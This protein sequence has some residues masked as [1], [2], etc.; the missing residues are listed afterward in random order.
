M[1]HSLALVLA[2]AL[3]WSGAP[4]SPVF[5]ASVSGIPGFTPDTQLALFTR[6]DADNVERKTGGRN[7]RYRNRLEE[8]LESLPPEQ[9]AEARQHYEEIEEKRRLLRAELESLPPEERAARMEELR[10]QFSAM[11]EE[12]HAD[13]QERFRARW[14]NAT[15]DERRA[16]CANARSHCAEGHRRS[17]AMAK[18][19]C[20]SF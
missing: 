11:K 1:K 6:A 18:G 15:D 9:R 2:G 5:A 16:F 8:R 19:H 4:V 7:G 13:F 14:E 17:C 10:A 3:L 20:D 12:H